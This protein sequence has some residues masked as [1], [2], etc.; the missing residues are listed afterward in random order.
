MN[1][2][3]QT[4]GAKVKLPA[5]GLL[6]IGVLRIVRTL[7]LVWGMLFGFSASMLAVFDLPWGIGEMLAE[8]HFDFSPVSIA[9]NL[10][11]ST[12]L[13]WAALQML[14]LRRHTVAV[15]ASVIAM[16][17]CWDGCLG[18]PIGIWAL[19][20]LLKPEVKSAFDQ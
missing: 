18:L 13:I 2:V 7:Y 3:Q 10:V 5:V 6:L 20:V 17:P 9:I 8:G 14:E 19:I 12:F 4:S 1:G 16:I 15:V 11:G